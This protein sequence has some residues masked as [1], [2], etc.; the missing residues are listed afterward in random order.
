MI[1]KGVFVFNKLLLY[2]SSS[3][4]TWPED[5]TVIHFDWKFSFLTNQLLTIISETLM[6]TGSY[7][8][9]SIYR[10]EK[11]TGTNW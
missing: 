4:N 10:E 8:F 11:Q 2:H 5:L 9:S 6:R 3:L 7:L 1:V